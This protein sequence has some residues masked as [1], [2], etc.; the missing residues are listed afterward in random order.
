M[1]IVQVASEAVPF[2]KTGGL[3]DVAGALPIHLE[4]LKHKITLFVPFYKQIKESKL[5]LTPTNI[6]IEV[7]IGDKTSKAKIWTAPIPE[8]KATAYFIQ[9]D[10]YYNRENL[11]STS[12][13]DYPDNSERFIFFSRAVLE[14]IKALNINAD[15]IHCH[16]WQT[17][18]IPAY[19]KTIYSADPLFKNIKTVFTIHNLAYQG[20][21]W[22]WDMKLTG[23][24]WSLFNWK[25][26]EFWGKLNFLKGGLVFS[27]IL[28]TVS[29]RYSHEIQTAEFG[30]G[31]DGVLR[32]RQ[33]NLYGII[34]GVEYTD[35]NPEIDKLI[36]A[37]YSVNSMDGKYT[38]RKSLQESQNLP[39]SNA[40]IIGM[41]T[42]LAGQKGL[43]ILVEIFDELM[44]E[45][46]QFVLLGTGEEKYHKAM[47]DIQKKY[48]TKTGINLKFDNSL[49]HL[50][51]AGSDMF[52]MPSRYEPCGLNQLYSLKY[53]TPP[54]VRETGGLA[55]TIAN[56]DG[57]NL[58]TATGFSFR[59]HTGQELLKTIKNALSTFQNKKVWKQIIKNGMKQDWSWKRSAGEYNKLYLKLKG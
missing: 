49:A 28:T 36:P 45:D 33:A 14:T 25:Q 17:A 56:Y 34:N 13:G 40:P 53:G 57:S 23:F 11:Y 22:H 44:K 52:L 5:K 51:T 31:L 54:I 2:A 55:D 18:L 47:A 42:R 12:K 39:A 15:I 3:A 4:Q 6:A 26:F 48:R 1:H 41:I 35:W 29:P 10:D 46:V 37:N 19:I 20:L 32:E 30:A 50:I 38:C 16:D 43:D 59:E 58:K 27:D 21:F 8:S 9:N 7:K 24:D